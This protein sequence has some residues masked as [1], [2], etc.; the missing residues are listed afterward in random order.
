[1]GHPIAAAAVAAGR[2]HPVH[3]VCTNHILQLVGY[4]TA[5]VLLTVPVTVTV[6][7]YR[8]LPLPTWIGLAVRDQ[9]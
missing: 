4:L 7:A 3:L 2:S 1:M 9:V 5:A 8:L 6:T